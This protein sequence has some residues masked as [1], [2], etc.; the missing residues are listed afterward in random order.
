MD[1][2]RFFS[3]SSDTAQVILL[4]SL[5]DPEKY[6]VTFSRFR[7]TRRIKM[8]QVELP[9]ELAMAKFQYWSEELEE[10]GWTSKS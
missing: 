7:G 8:I 3:R 6:T 10:N 9:L 4:N 1:K 2:R 5:A